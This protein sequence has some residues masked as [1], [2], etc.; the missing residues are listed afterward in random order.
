M[1]VRPVLLLAAAHGVQVLEHVL[2]MDVSWTNTSVRADTCALERA[3]SKLVLRRLLNV[4]GAG[5]GRRW[6]L[7]AALVLVHVN[8][9]VLLV[10]L[11]L[12]RVLLLLLLLLLVQGAILDLRP[13]NRALRLER[14]SSTTS[15]VVIEIHLLHLQLRLLLLQVLVWGVSAFE[16]AAMLEGSVGSNRGTAELLRS[17]IVRS[18][19]RGT[20]DQRN[21]LIFLSDLRLGSDTLLGLPGLLHLLELLHVGL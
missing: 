2:L 15:T 11:R 14:R 9:Q 1:V 4:L 10:L 19:S 13:S 7:E 17:S 18:N 6:L 8:L 3:K 16:L 12:R 20:R 5:L 21:E